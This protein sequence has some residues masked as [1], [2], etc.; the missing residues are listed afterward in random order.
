VH[1]LRRYTGAA[2][3]PAGALRSPALS[4]V[5]DYIEANLDCPVALAELAAVA[6]LSVFHFA[7]VFRAAVGTTPHRYLLER[8]VGRARTMLAIAPTPIIGWRRPAG[9]PAPH[10]ATAFRR[11]IRSSPRLPAPGPRLGVG[12]PAQKN[13]PVPRP[14]SPPLPTPTPSETPGTALE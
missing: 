1:L 3:P 6:G 4:L 5:V 8:R 14:Q 11:I 10:F 12:W 9:S 13:S 2:R 7:R